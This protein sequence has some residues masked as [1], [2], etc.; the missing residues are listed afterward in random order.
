MNH[1][2]IFN[3]LLGSIYVNPLNHLKL[4]LD[5]LPSLLYKKNRPLL[6]KKNL[7]KA[8]VDVLRIRLDRVWPAVF[9]PIYL[10]L[11]QWLSIEH[12]ELFFALPLLDP[13]RH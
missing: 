2:L 9:L 8:V 1:A 11:L 7:V 3:H 10:W 12:E 4:R 13:E 6:H 5:L